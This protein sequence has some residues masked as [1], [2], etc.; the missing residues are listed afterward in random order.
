MAAS[1][2]YL[3]TKVLSGWEES[4]KEMQLHSRTAVRKPT[5]EPCLSCF[6]TT[7]LLFHS[8]LFNVKTKNYFLEKLNPRKNIFKI[9]K[10]IIYQYFTTIYSIQQYD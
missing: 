8:Q 4:E 7:E 10:T 1:V 3:E 6:I 5:E 2:Y 9:K